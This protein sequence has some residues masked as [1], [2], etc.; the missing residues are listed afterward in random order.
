[1]IFRP[2]R[3]NLNGFLRSLG[4]SKR[5]SNLDI[6][7]SSNYIDADGSERDPWNIFKYSTAYWASVNADDNHWIQINLKNHYISL[8]N[9]TIRSALVNLS[10]RGW[11]FE[12]S[13]DNFSSY[14]VLDSVSNY[15]MEEDFAAVV[16][17]AVYN[18]TNIPAFNS[19]RVSTTRNCVSGSHMR[20][21]SIELFGR[22]FSSSECSLI[23]K[24]RCISQHLFFV[25]FVIS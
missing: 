20:I 21:S 8:E 5:K 11:K 13:N 3:G 7:T 24:R 16:R 25:F 4:T 2:S 14:V 9:Y 6:Y 12:A 15:V 18:N 10:I 1:M 22:V 23:T 19:F 17:P